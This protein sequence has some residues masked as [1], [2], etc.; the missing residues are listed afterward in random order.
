MSY[1]TSR[2]NNLSTFHY[3]HPPSPCFSTSS[4]IFHRSFLLNSTSHV[5]APF[6]AAMSRLPT[7]FTPHL[8]LCILLSQFLLNASTL[9]RIYVPF[10]EP[11]SSSAS[12]S[13]PPP[14]LLNFLFTP[15]YST[16]CALVF[17]HLRPLILE[18]N[19]T[20]LPSHTSTSSLLI[21]ALKMLPLPFIYLLPTSSPVFLSTVR[22]HHCL[23]DVIT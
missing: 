20:P 13:S 14:S 4:S 3:P 5:L 11:P 22:H 8:P 18:H 17:M 16:G 9:H 12:L 7:T 1:T 23:V 15:P 6:I 19:L 10:K 2:L 21:S